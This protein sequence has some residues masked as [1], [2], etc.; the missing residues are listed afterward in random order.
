[1]SKTVE[2]LVKDIGQGCIFGTIIWAVTNYNKYRGKTLSHEKR[3]AMTSDLQYCAI[4]NGVLC[5][6]PYKYSIP[7]G[8]LSFYIMFSPYP[9]PTQ[10]Q[11]NRMLDGKSPTM[12]Q[13][14]K[15]IC[16]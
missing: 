10:K 4:T 9:F 12:L 2:Q 5:T 13:N 6:L 7:L 11:F 16:F 14:I 3:I 1:M 15:E 8:A